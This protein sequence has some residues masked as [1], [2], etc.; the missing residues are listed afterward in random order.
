MD[1][2]VIPEEVNSTTPSGL[3][4]PSSPVV[5]Y[6]KEKEEEN[7]RLRKELMVS[8]RQGMEMR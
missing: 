5:E 2:L 4:S 7:E 8:E 3:A 1:G 6:W